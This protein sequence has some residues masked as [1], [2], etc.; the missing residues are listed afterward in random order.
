ME[1]SFRVSMTIAVLRLNVLA[2]FFAKPVLSAYLIHSDC[3]QVERAVIAHAYICSAST[4]HPVFIASP[5]MINKVQVFPPLAPFE[6]TT[7]P[8][9]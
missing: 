6:S 5:T 9:A 3:C 1:A 2:V 8:V 4:A 7:E